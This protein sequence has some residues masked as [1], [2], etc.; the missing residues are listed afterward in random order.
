MSQTASTTKT[1]APVA[2]PQV[3]DF[4]KHAWADAKDRIKPDHRGETPE[5][6]KRR[7]TETILQLCA[8]GMAYD[9]AGGAQWKPIVTFLEYELGDQHNITGIWSEAIELELIQPTDATG[10]AYRVADKTFRSRP[11][12][13]PLSNGQEEYPKKKE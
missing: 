4:I 5:L 9:K 13:L 7:V 1:A 3:K 11:H 2:A 8:L 10:A 12:L 6:F